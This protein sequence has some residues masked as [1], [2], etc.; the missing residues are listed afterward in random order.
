M[1]YELEIELYELGDCALESDFDTP[2]DVYKTGRFTLDLDSLSM[3][4]LEDKEDDNNGPGYE[5]TYKLLFEHQIQDGEDEIPVN[6]RVCLSVL[7]E[8]KPFCTFTG[9]VTGKDSNKSSIFMAEI[10]MSEYFTHKETVDIF[11]EAFESELRKNPITPEED[12]W[13]DIASVNTP[14]NNEKWKPISNEWS[15][16][17]KAVQ[18]KKGIEVKGGILVVTE[19]VEFIADAKLVDRGDD[20]YEIVK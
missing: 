19:Y 14:Q 5:P 2:T 20:T 12:T 13:T 16:K 1:E 7:N 4:L 11:L 3:Y 8:K 15:D 9:F 10:K 6:S 18:S 17:V